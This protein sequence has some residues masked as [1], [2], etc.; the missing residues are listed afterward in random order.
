M[1]AVSIEKGKCS[2]NLNACL[3]TYV[4]PVIL[5]L[6]MPRSSLIEHANSMHW[7]TSMLMQSIIHTAIEKGKVYTRVQFIM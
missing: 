3:Y 4:E 6:C 7:H 1:Y 5:L 2:H